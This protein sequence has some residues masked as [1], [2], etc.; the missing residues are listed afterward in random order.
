[1]FHVRTQEA[2]C[3][4]EADGATGN[5]QPALHAFLWHQ[6][7]GFG[8]VGASL[9]PIRDHR[10]VAHGGKTSVQQRRR[11]NDLFLSVRQNRMTGFGYVGRR[12]GKLAAVRCSTQHIIC[13]PLENYSPGPTAICF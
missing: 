8:A 6:R 12:P 3:A 7:W 5:T 11:K 9:A 1:M 4:K 10:F 13:R 2:E